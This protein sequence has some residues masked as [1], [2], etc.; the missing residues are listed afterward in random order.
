MKCLIV[1]D[2]DLAR[3]STRQLAEQSSILQVIGECR[4]GLEAFEFLKNNEVDLLILDVE[5]PDMSGIE[6]LKL[7][8]EKPIVVLSTSKRQYAV[9]AFEMNV[10]DYLVKPVTLTRFTMALQKANDIYTSKNSEISEIEQEYIFIKENKSFKKVNLGEI[11]WIEAMGD[12]V[13]IKTESKWHIVHSTLKT[14]EA[15]MNPQKFLRIH[16]SYFIAIDKI[17]FIEEGVVYIANSPLP[18]ADTYK[19]SL[20]KRLN[21][22]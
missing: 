8:P 19:S 9:E 2:N 22:L 18:V 13:K 1:D 4:S 16:R 7:L 5:M 15:R 14:L 17:D 21:L 20:L 6:L 11:L 10:A 3:M 12:Y